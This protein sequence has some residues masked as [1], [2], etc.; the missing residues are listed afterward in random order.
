MLGRAVGPSLTGTRRRRVIYRPRINVGHRRQMSAAESAN[1]SNLCYLRTRLPGRRLVLAIPK[2]LVS[3]Q[4]S[5][6]LMS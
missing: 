2:P 1:H 6:V 3:P 5:Q 4:P